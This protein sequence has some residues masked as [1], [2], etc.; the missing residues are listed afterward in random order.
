MHGR[1][2]ERIQLVRKET[3]HRIG[4]IGSMVLRNASGYTQTSLRTLCSA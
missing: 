1:V 4:Y 2:K 3:A